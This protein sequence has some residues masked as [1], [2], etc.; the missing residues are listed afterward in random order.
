MGNQFSSDGSKI[1]P[2]FTVG[3]L[4]Y[5]PRKRDPGSK[6]R[7]CGRHLGGGK[8]VCHHGRGCRKGM[9]SGQFE[10]LEA[11]EDQNG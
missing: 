5:K 11:G 6:C 8:R 9:T 2:D 7:M 3:G 10:L 4:S 1:W